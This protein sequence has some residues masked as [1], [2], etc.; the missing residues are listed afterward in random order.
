MAR[1]RSGRA[2][3]EAVEGA[4][5]EL[6][7]SLSK[8]RAPPELL[9]EV[10]GGLEALPANAVI[11]AEANVRML[12]EL[13]IDRSSIFLDLIRPRRSALDLLALQPR[14]GQLFLFHRDGHV[15]QAALDGFTEPPATAFFLAALVLRLN[16]WARPVRVAAR[17]CGERLFPRV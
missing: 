16:D 6:G 9:D 5:V 15:R 7:R 12:A 8:G 10:M 4:L 1:N 14:L 11:W 2:V 3:P 17:Y 13:Y